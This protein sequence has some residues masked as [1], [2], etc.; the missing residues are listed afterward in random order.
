MVGFM[1]G[2]SD[3]ESKGNVWNKTS[4]GQNL[5]ALKRDPLNHR[6]KVKPKLQKWVC[7]KG[8]IHGV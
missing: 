4:I 3:L 8:G 5:A 6:E 2:M 1:A 7:G